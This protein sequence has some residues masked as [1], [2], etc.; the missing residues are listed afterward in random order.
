MS[1]P[2]E[3]DDSSPLFRGD[4]SPSEVG[5]RADR[6]GRSRLMRAQ[7][8]GAHPPSGAVFRALAENRSGTKAH[9]V[10]IAVMR[11]PTPDARAH[12]ATR[13]GACAPRRFPR[14]V[15][16]RR[17]VA[18]AKAVT[19]HR[20]PKPR[21]CGRF[22][23]V[24]FPS[25]SIGVHPWLKHLSAKKFLNAFASACSKRTN[26]LTGTAW[27]RH[28]EARIFADDS[29][30]DQRGGDFSPRRWEKLK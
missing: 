7:A 4:W 1:E 11:A 18:C 23:S 24:R 9:E 22:V 29:A 5:V 2:V 26:R 15:V 25:V 3:C 6:E 14:V 12:P 8:R 20:T 16:R 27:N 28:S 30:D 13:E 10:S 17:Q 19:S 21:R